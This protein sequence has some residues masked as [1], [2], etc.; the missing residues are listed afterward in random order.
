MNRRVPLI[1]LLFLLLPVHVHGQMCRNS[2]LFISDT[3]AP[4]WVETLWLR[5][6]HNTESTAALFDDIVT[7]PATDL[8][9]TGDVVN[10]ACKASRWQAMDTLIAHARR[11]GKHVHGLLG[12]HEVMR[13]A[14]L[15]EANFQQRFP[16]HVRTGYTVRADSI[17]VLMMNSNV[18]KLGAEQHALQQAWYDSTLTALDHDPSVRAIIVCCHHSPYTDSKI[19]GCNSDVQRDLVPAFLKAKHTA[20]F[21]SGHAHLFQH[22]EQAGKHFFVI[23]GGGGLHHPMHKKKLDIPGVVNLDAD[24]APLFHYLSVTPCKDQLLV[25]SLPLKEDRSGMGAA[26][27]FALPWP[28]R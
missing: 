24:H 26:R 5:T 10:L 12:N 16:E 25:R 7:R 19:V 15:G 13:D 27:E 1:R 18:E 17:A 20:I 22:F 4:M 8:F 3:Q 21:I 6:H 28:E 11:S 14:A 9:I 2:L 23:G